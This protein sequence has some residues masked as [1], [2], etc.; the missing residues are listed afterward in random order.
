MSTSVSGLS[1]II[2]IVLNMCNLNGVIISILRIF[3]AMEDKISHQHI[4]MNCLCSVTIQLITS[5][6]HLYQYFLWDRSVSIVCKRVF[7]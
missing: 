5:V 4:I 7:A 1:I 3:I 2:V 6:Y